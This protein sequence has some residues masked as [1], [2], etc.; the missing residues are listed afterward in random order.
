[1]FS[2]QLG[3]YMFQLAHINRGG[4]GWGLTL[5][6]LM[7]VGGMGMDGMGVTHVDRGSRG[8]TIEQRLKE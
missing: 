1:M 4:Q 8:V 2:G 5:M 6:P 7:G 3:Y